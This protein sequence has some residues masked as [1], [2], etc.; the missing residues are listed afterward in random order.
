MTPPQETGRE[1]GDAI[2][3][4][5]S[6]YEQRRAAGADDRRALDQVAIELEL[7]IEDCAVAVGREDLLTG[8]GGDWRIEWPDV[9][10][11]DFRVE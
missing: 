8:P 7:S 10:P 3:L 6:R 4:I 2:E 5:R 11:P 9:G 1:P